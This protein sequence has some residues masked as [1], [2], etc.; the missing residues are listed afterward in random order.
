MINSFFGH[1]EAYVSQHT[2]GP[3]EAVYT[4]D[5]MV[6]WYLN[7]LIAMKPII[8]TLVVDGLD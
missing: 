4:Y 6:L 2:V 3:V 7:R 5:V 8:T 1:N